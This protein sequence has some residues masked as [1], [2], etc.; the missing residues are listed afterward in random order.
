MDSCLDRDS[1]SCLQTSPVE[2]CREGDSASRMETRDV[3]G[4]AP[5]LPLGLGL[6][7]LGADLG[8][9]AVVTFSVQPRVQLQLMRAMARHRFAGDMAPSHFGYSHAF[10]WFNPPGETT[11]P[12]SEDA[13][14]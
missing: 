7:F 4:W 11:P 9:P 14:V 5:V 6:R 3:Q 10:G 13:V 1:R 12:P 2:K 8:L